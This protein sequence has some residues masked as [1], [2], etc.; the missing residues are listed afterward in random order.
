MID[1]KKA[2]SNCLR[3]LAYQIDKMPTSMLQELAN[4]NFDVRI[5]TLD[6]KEKD[7]KRQPAKLPDSIELHEMELALRGMQNREQGLSFL[8]EKGLTKDGL[9]LL[10]KHLDLP[11]QKRENIKRRSEKIIETTIG[12]K[13]RSQAIQGPIKKKGNGITNKVRL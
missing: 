3:K 13:L 10:A 7:K 12:Y 9:V 4:G 8:S 11:V 2:F 6:K 5:E 1:Y